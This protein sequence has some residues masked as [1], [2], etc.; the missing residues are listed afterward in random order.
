MAE[1]GRLG[2]S[3]GII[4]VDRRICVSWLDKKQAEE[5]KKDKHF[6]TESAPLFRN[7]HCRFLINTTNMNAAAFH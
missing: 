2:A 1:S 4:P 7:I 6:P 3:N 5:I